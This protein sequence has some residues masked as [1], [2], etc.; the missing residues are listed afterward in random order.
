LTPRSGSFRLIKQ[1]DKLGKIK[2]MTTEVDFDALTVKTVQSNGA[3]EDLTN[4][5]GAAFALSEWH[6]IARGEFPVVNPYI[7]ANAEFAGGQR[8]HKLPENFPREVFPQQ[9]RRIKNL[10]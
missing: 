6:F 2:F 7:A 4:L 5:Y 9:R 8:L 1:T 3:M 10:S